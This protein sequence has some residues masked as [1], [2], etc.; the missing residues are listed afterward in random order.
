MKLYAAEYIDCIYESAYTVISLHE[1][2]SSANKAI[3]EHKKSM[4]SNP[5]F[6]FMDWKVTEYEV[7][8]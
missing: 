8:P 3:K 4:K 1:K 2:K 6:S 5:C 7:K